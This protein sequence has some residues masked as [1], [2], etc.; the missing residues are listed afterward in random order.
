VQAFT[1]TPHDKSQTHGIS[2]FHIIQIMN[3]YL[4]GEPSETEY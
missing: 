2:D 3:S 4:A 1:E